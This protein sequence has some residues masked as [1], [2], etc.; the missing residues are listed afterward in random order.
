M[1]RRRSMLAAVL[2][3]VS[4]VSLVFVARSASAGVSEVDL[5]YRWAPVHHQDSSSANYE[6]DYLAQVDYDGD[7]DSRNNWE[8]LSAD[9]ADLTGAVYYS[10]VETGTH[11]FIAYS[12]FH[13]RDWKVLGSHENDMEGMVA[14]IRKDDSE[15]GTFEAMV[16][17]A[18]DHFYSYVPPG[19][20]YTAGRESIDGQVVM[21]TH[22]E[23]PHPTTFQEARGHGAYRWDGKEFPG[24]DGIVYVP[25]RDE[26]KEPS[27]GDDRSVPYRLVDTFADGGLWA[28]RADPLT[29]AEW[30]TFGGDDGRDDAA[31]TAWGWDDK[32]DGVE[33]GLMA[34]DPARLIDEYFDDLG[35]FDRA[36]TRNPYAAGV[37]EAAAG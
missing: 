7:W 23:R 25:D 24:G 15:F 29:F 2:A 19:S 8:N 14:A 35:S 6:A 32:D 22:D 1:T 20:P 10:V 3:T 18:H 31:H 21:D 30:A 5:A 28:R 9:D 12:F 37:R 27:G 17:I 11:W 34:T 26:G 4:A 36:Y 16:T 13:P 33:A